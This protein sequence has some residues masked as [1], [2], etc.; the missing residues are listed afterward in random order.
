MEKIDLIVTVSG[1]VASGK[2]R[3][4][5]MLKNFLRENGFEVEF[6]GNIDHPREFDFDERVSEN[7]D[8]VIEHIKETRKITLK[9]VQLAR[10][11]KKN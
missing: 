10:N 3:L 9:E 5:Y 1:Q 11:W 6:N 7:F 4:T 2:S 8:E